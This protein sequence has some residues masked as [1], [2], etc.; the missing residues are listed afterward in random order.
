LT[1]Q[2]LD[3]CV[4]YAPTQIEGRQFEPSGTGG[5][6]S[7]VSIGATF[8]SP[9][10][11]AGAG[12]GGG[13][14]AGSPFTGHEGGN[15]GFPDGSHAFG[16][17]GEGGTQ[18]HGGVSFGGSVEEATAGSCFTAS[19]PGKGG[20]DV[21]YEYHVTEELRSEGATGGG[22]YCGGGGGEAATLGT[23]G[24]GGGSDYCTET[25]AVTGCTISAGAGT[26]TVAGS[27]PGD[28]QVTLTY[29]APTVQERLASLLTA[30]T[31]AR[32]HTRPPLM[33]KVMAIQHF[34]AEQKERPACLRLA[35]FIRF[36]NARIG[37]KL[38]NEQAESFDKQADE[39]QVALGC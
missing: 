38:T 20:A 31:G 10:L 26:G 30:V 15:A 1:R 37:T 36:V 29:T 19:G 24:G 17:G 13:G 3:V 27:A 33:S 4:D 34:V 25:S 23:S 2:T 18:E 9:V 8:A 21:T 39:I 6:A 7:G 16:D 14:D 11:V 35:G 5:G 32:A 22:G 12:G 28:A